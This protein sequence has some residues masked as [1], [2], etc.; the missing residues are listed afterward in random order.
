MNPAIQKVI[1]VADAE[2]G[3]HEGFSNGHHDNL[4]KY[5]AQVPGLE[6]ANG[7]PWCAVFVSWVA[8]KAGVP[9]IFP[10]TASCDVAAQWFKDR[11]QWSDVPRGPGDQVFYG[12]LSDQTHTGVLID[13]DASVIVTVE[14]NTNTSGSREGDGVYRKTRLRRDPF[15]VGYGHPAFPPVAPVKIT[16]VT[17]ARALLERA[18]ARAKTPA[19]AAAIRKALAKL[20]G[21]R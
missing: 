13:F 17:Q 6:W 20:A 5:A 10:R 14:G 8:L 21:L 12:T 7:Q 1:A 16:R 11:G 4:E 18:L 9:A 2:V 15:V 3:Y 19:R